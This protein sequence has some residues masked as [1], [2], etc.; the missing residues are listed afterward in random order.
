MK[1]LK[2]IGKVLFVFVSLLVVFVLIV[3]GLRAYNANKYPFMNESMDGGDKGL[4]ET[5]ADITAIDGTYLNGFHFRPAEKRHRGVVVTFGGSEG[6]PDY[7]RAKRLYDEGYEVLALFFWGQDNQ[8]DTLANVPLD[9][10]DEVN[11]YIED[12]VSDP[13][14][15]TVIGTS[16][17]AEFVTLLAQHGF[18]VD[19]VVAFAPAHYSYSGLDFSRGEDLPSFTLRGEPIAYASF[20]DASVGT[21]LKTIWSSITGAPSSYRETYEQAAEKAEEKGN[22]QARIDLSGYDG[23]VLLFAGEADHMWQSSVAAKALAEQNPSIETHIYPDAGHFF[24][25]N[26]DDLP[27]GW[28]IVVG[29]SH[30]GNNKAHV[31]SE[32]ILKERLAEW[33]G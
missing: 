31:E 5:T 11:K 19:N 22:N 30:E 23:N 18:K 32:K 9:Q 25:E 28:Q 16:K 3:F 8:K 10:F 20:R 15:V 12:N 4:Y 7:D 14:P 29:G 17:G 27:N 1:V 33:H 21:G 26:S 6:S 13:T 24:S 2:V